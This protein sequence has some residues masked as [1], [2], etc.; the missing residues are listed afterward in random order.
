MKWTRLNF[1]LLQEIKHVMTSTRLSSYGI[2]CEVIVLLVTRLKNISVQAAGQNILNGTVLLDKFDP[3]GQVWSSFIKFEQVWSIL[4][5][6]VP[7]WT[8]LI[9]FGQVWSN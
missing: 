1:P 9:Q 6:C 3:L 8:S 5:K 7:I 2:W 4:D